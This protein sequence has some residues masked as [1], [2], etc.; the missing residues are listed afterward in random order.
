MRIFT[1]EVKMDNSA[2]EDPMELPQILREIARLVAEGQT[3]RGIRDSNGNRVGQ[4]V[5]DEIDV[6]AQ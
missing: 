3:G 2:F 5:M 4:W 1:C 6:E